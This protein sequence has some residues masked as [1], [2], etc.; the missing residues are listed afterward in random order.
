MCALTE[1]VGP[2]HKPEKIDI[3]ANAEFSYYLFIHAA[4]ETAAEEEF[5][6]RPHLKGLEF[7]PKLVF[8]L[9]RRFKLSL[10]IIS[11]L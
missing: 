4:F 1:R 11:M 2:E 6:S 7:S 5:K 8:D 9:I 3:V 10:K